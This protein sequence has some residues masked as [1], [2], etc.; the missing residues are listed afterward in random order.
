MKGQLIQEGNTTKEFF[1][2]DDEN[3]LVSGDPTYQNH[4]KTAVDFKIKNMRL[5]RES[6]GE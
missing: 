6:Q 4:K 3:A 5:D 2:K 1:K